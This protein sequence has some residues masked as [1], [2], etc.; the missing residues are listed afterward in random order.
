MFKDTVSD[1]YLNEGYLCWLV[2]E[3]LVETQIEG[4]PFLNLFPVLLI[5]EH[6]GSLMVHVR[7]KTQ[8]R[9][10]LQKKENALP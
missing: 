6:T 3:E 10:L 1:R 4:N 2:T 8:V 7:T 9:Q 5:L